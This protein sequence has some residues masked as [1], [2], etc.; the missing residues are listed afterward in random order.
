MSIQEDSKKVAKIMG[1]VQ[2]ILARFMEKICRVYGSNIMLVIAIE[3]ATSCLAAAIWMVEC[4]GGNTDEF[5]GEL[6]SMT[7]DKL[8]HTREVASTQNNCSIH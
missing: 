5:F 1:Q 7:K 2:S 6:L 8:A 4:R 3:I